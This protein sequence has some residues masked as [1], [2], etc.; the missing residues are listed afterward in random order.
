MACGQGLSAVRALSAEMS[1]MGREDRPSSP[2]TMPIAAP[3][4]GRPKKALVRFKPG[5]VD[6][7]FS[8][9]DVHHDCED[10]SSA[11]S[12]EAEV[13]KLLVATRTQGLT[14]YE[15]PASSEF[16]APEC[17][18]TY[19][20]ACL[21]DLDGSDPI[22]EAESDSGEDSD[23]EAEQIN[24][25]DKEAA[26][27]DHAPGKKDGDVA[28][29]MAV[30]TRSLTSFDVVSDSSEDSDSDSSDESVNEA[31]GEDAE[32]AAVRTAAPMRSF[33]SL[34][35]PDPSS[36]LEAAEVDEF[37]RLHRQQ[38]TEDSDSD[39][40]EEWDSEVEGEDAE[41]ADVR[42]RS[43]ARSLT[44]LDIP[45]PSSFLLP[46]MMEAYNL[47]HFYSES[48]SES[49]GS[50]SDSSESQSVHEDAGG[51]AED[52]TDRRAAMPASS[53]PLEPQLVESNVMVHLTN[54]SH[55]GKE[56]AGEANEAPTP[57][58]HSRRAVMRFPSPTEYLTKDEL[59]AVLRVFA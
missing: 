2:A 21:S 54:A 24:P 7:R 59:A 20:R 10:N 15:L 18:E 3:P 28:N 39:S 14:S 13:S 55:S 44:A 52:G 31:A 12:E 36:F 6:E 33:T 48:A 41:N 29:Q 19:R 9:G 38:Y 57:P 53:S 26:S 22:E 35:I 42:A 49:E 45:D 30:P 23:M 50:D 51:S 11:K 1:T 5:D 16:L 32:G 56:S 17:I 43:G 37:N 25:V 46:R 47:V 34:N 58:L 27:S 4:K 40:S 8:E